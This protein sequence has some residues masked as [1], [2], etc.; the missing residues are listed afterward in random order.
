MALCTQVLLTKDLSMVRASTNTKMMT[1][2]KA[3]SGKVLETDKEFVIIL[4][5]VMFMMA[6]GKKI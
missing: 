3:N 6:N 5:Q 2:M 4:D 1:S